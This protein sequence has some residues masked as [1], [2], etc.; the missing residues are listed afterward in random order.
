MQLVGP[1]SAERRRHLET[2]LVI[3]LQ[4][5]IRTRQIDHSPAYE[6][7]TA[8]AISDAQ[9]DAAAA[10]SP[11]CALQFAASKLSAARLDLCAI[12][13]PTVALTY[14]ASLVTSVRLEALATAHPELALRYAAALISDARFSIASAAFPAI[15]L[16]FAPARLDASVLATALAGATPCEIL[17]AAGN[18]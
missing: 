1:P 6:Y 18:Q 16:R 11:A 10:L 15:A 14:A 13:A 12:A 4:Q 8:V 7:R 2:A 17:K 5:G 9:I 3:T